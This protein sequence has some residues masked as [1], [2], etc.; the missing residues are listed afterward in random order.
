M[1]ERSGTS[2]R[3]EALKALRGEPVA[4][5][6]FIARMDLWYTYHKNRGTLPPQYQNATLADIQRD[7][8]IG[9]LGF[10]AWIPGFYR[11]EYSGGV[12]VHTRW[13][14]NERLTE[15][16]T[17]YG[18]LSAREVISEAMQAADV[19]PLHTEYPFKGPQDYDALQCLFEHTRV[20]E[21]YEEYARDRAAIG[22]DGL[23]LPYTGWVPMHLLMKEYIGY[24]QFYY[25]LH[26]HL[27]RLERVAEAVTAVQMEI[28]RVG[29]GS[30]ADVVEV[31]GNYDRMMTPHRIFR[32]Y[33][34]PFYQQ[35]VPVLHAAGKAV[36]LHGDGDMDAELLRL[37]RE[38]GV[39]AVE[40]LTPRPMTTI[41][42]RQARALWGDAV[43]L[44]GG[45]PAILM[46]PTYSDEQVEEFLEDLFAAVAPGRRFILGF[47]DNVP[48]DG[49]FSRIL[50]VTEFYHAHSAYPLA[51]GAA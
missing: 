15:Y 6:P 39:D 21:N 22:E 14:G 30:P 29:A 35:A 27:P 50:Q 34:L 31:G 17:P 20:V 51:G 38:T 16:V 36:A 47:G 8:G 33:F 42:V 13:E 12:E 1:R 40:A 4:R 10:G 37:M 28:V 23:S 18:T 5:I 9:V 25:E 49:L 41:D 2:I 11:L 24:S 45:I 43:T 48:T 32:T 19:T 46:T 26:D 44:W 3:T 7:L